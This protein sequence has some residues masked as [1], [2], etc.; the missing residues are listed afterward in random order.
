MVRQADKRLTILGVVHTHPGSLRH[1]SDGDFRGDRLWVSQLRGREGIFGIGT[2]D[3]RD[4]NPLLF[5]PPEKPHCQIF[6]N[7]CFH[8]YAL[9]E[10][11]SRYRPLPVQ[12]TLGPDLARPLHTLWPLV[13]KYSTPL[14]RLSIQQSGLTFQVKENALWVQIPLADPFSFLR[15]LLQNEKICY[16]LVRDD[17]L[18]EV[19]PKETRLDRAAYLILAELT[20]KE[21]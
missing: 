14:E 13:E 4:F 18:I 8:W 2:A 11:D 15:I 9:G 16:Y 17:D 6:Q 5:S 12:L 19:D 7:L 1:P 3:V 21:F 20:E 10:G